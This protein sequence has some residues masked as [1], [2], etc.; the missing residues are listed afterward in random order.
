MPLWKC[1]VAHTDWVLL[2]WYCQWH[3]NDTFGTGQAQLWALCIAR[4]VGGSAHFEACF[5]RLQNHRHQNH[6]FEGVSLR[7][8]PPF[9]VLS[10]QQPKRIPRPQFGPMASGLPHFRPVGLSQAV[11]QKW[12]DLKVHC[13][14][15]S[16][17]GH[18]WRAQ[19]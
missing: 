1:P 8:S 6:S 9:L 5:W 16:I 19:A 7:R 10:T 18:V 14:N 17:R 4:M 15:Q 3:A 2:P 11:N 12:A 13:T